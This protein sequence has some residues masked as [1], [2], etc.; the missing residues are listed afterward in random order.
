MARLRRSYVL[1]TSQTSYPP[2]TTLL[3]SCPPHTN[4]ELHTEMVVVWFILLNLL[5]VLTATRL[6]KTSMEK[7]SMKFSGRDII[8]G[9]RDIYEVNRRQVCLL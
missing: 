3:P 6:T 2:R 4:R 7:K 8:S 1:S 9:K 5:P